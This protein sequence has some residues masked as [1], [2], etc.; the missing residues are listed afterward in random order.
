MKKKNIFIGALFTFALF[1]TSCQKDVEVWDSATLDYSG[2]Y[3]VKV[4]S[5]DMS[6]TYADYDGTELSIYNTAANTVNEM[7][8]ENGWPTFKSK[9][10]FTG[11]PTSF[12]STDTEFDKLTDN[13][14]AIKLPTAPATAA[15]QTREEKRS[16]LR[17]LIVDGKILPKAA[18][19]KGGNKADSLYLKV[20]LYSGTATFKTQETPKAG[21]KDP[22]KP[23]Y[24]WVLLSVAHD[25]TQDDVIVIGGYM[26]TGFPEDAY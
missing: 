9:F 3:V 7:W 21:W 10:F 4:M 25:A 20:K 2:R 18:T 14:Q 15:G 17:A 12:K 1:F 23:E 6:E 5:E 26:Y 24:K 11:N 8:M 13:L 19:T 22:A 16:N